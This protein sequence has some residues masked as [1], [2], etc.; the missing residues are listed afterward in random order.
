MASKQ[1]GAFGSRKGIRKPAVMIQGNNL[2]FGHDPKPW[3]ADYR[4]L[5]SQATALT[6]SAGMVLR[7]VQ[8]DL[9]AKTNVVKVNEDLIVLKNHVAAYKGRLALLN[10]E[11]DKIERETPRITMEKVPEL[12]NHAEAFQVFMND[13][14]KV[15]MFA[16][17]KVLD[18]FRAVGEDIAYVCPYS[19]GFQK[20]VGEHQMDAAT[21]EAAQVT[22]AE[23]LMGADLAE[24]LPTA[25][26]KVH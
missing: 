24:Q 8:S 1:S 5:G 23:D 4:M 9:L 3:I 18:H 20:A 11:T 16:A 25:E 22:T 19:E 17:D 15:V 7:Y 2:Q 21:F 13:W 14:A 6:T 10:A 26:D 12:L